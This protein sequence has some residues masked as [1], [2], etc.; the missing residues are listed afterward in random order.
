LFGPN[1][2]TITLP[3]FLRGNFDLGFRSVETYRLFIVG[4]G[5]ILVVALSSV[6]DRT[7]FGAKLRAAVDNP[8]MARAMGINVDAL[9]SVAFAIGSGLAALGGALGAPMMPLEPLYPLKYL[10]LVLVVVS[11]AGHAGVWGLSITHKSAS[12]R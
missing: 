5:V 9:F 1:L 4:V 8:G 10:V 3:Q 6:F 7:T 11:Q 2:Y 12:W